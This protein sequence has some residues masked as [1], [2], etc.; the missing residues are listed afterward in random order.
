MNVIV[1]YCSIIEDW[2]HMYLEKISKLEK[3]CAIAV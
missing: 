1:P 3:D 2:L